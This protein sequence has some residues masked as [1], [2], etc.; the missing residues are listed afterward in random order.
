MPVASVSI[1]T[2]HWCYVDSAHRVSRRAD[3]NGK[4]EFY[5]THDQL[6]REEAYKDGVEKGS[7]PTYHPFM[8]RDWRGGTRKGWDQYP[9]LPVSGTP[10]TS[11]NSR[12]LVPCAAL[13]AD[14][15]KKGKNQNMALKICSE[16][17]KEISDKAF[18]CPHC[19]ATAVMTFL[20]GQVREPRFWVVL[21]ILFLLV[22]MGQLEALLWIALIIV[23]LP[24]LIRRGKL[25]GLHER[26]DSLE[27]KFKD[28]YASSS[29]DSQDSDSDS[30]DSGTH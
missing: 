28:W 17:S 5:R 16:C 2:I 21:L 13:V 24:W 4:W 30:Q 18:S 9:P 8:D 1:Q 6:S 3:P 23:V 11:R 14:L 26:L 22:L 15:R 19:G 7:Y 29:S 12:L 27:R 10:G 25:R 20:F